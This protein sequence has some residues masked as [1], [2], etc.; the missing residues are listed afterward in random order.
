MFG[1]DSPFYT[2]KLSSD[3]FKPIKNAFN[4]AVIPEKSS[5][6]NGFVGKDVQNKTD[7][8]VVASKLDYQN[9]EIV[10][11]S[12]NPIFRGFWENGKLLFVNALFF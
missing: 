3:L 8:T 12:D 10:F 6:K 11:F 1:I 2:L 5:S 4:A 9:G 7:N